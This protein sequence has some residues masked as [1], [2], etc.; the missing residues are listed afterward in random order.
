VSS[1]RTRRRR[2]N[3]HGDWFG[4][5]EDGLADVEQN[6]VLRVRVRREG[7]ET[8]TSTT[9]I[10]GRGRELFAEVCAQES[11]GH[12]REAQVKPNAVHLRPR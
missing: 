5:L 12:R 7:Y 9:H 11:R 8:I 10:A 6:E 3:R 1:A 2:I 4:L